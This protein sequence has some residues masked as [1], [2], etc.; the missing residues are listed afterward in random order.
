VNAVDSILMFIGIFTGI[1]ISLVYIL[2]FVRWNTEDIVSPVKQ[3]LD[4]MEKA[5]AGELEQYSLVRTNDEVGQLAEGYNQM[6]SRL[7]AYFDNINRLTEA[8]SRFVPR[9][10]LDILGKQDYTDIRLGDQVEREMT[11]LFSDMRSFTSMSEQMTPKQNFDFIN[12]YLGVM[13]PVIRKNNGFIDKYIG[14]AIMALFPGSPDDAANAALEMREALDF[15]NA[16]SASAGLPAI[17]IGIG[18][19][20]GR[21]MLGI[22]GTEGRMD[23][24]VISDAV[25]L[26]ARLEGLTKQYGCPAIISEDSMARLSNPENYKFRFLDRT[27]VKGKKEPVTIYELL[28]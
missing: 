3:L 12:A 5:G 27:Q 26:A 22:V 11:V 7:K 24:T 21:L 28:S 13:E 9:Q 2:F 6:T 18:I 23:G 8:Y 4:S 19:H 17:E 25:N 20:T 10:F 1:F 14:D 15:F 16:G